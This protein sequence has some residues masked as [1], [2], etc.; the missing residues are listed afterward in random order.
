M[1]KALLMALICLL[2]A[3]CGGTGETL[4]NAAPEETANT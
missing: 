1:R 4:E 2:L 3:G